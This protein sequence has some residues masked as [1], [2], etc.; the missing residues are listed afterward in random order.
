MPA[1]TAQLQVRVSPRE[2]AALRRRA[3]A[4]G[5]DVSSYVLARALPREA[6]TVAALL[7][8]LATASKRAFALAALGDL[9]RECSAGSFSDAVAHADV[10]ALAPYVQNYVAAMT[11]HA[12]HVHNVAPPEWVR[13][14]APLDEPHFGT[15]LVSLRP[16]LLRASPVAFKRRN[17]FIDATM[18]DRV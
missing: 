4:A 17:I 3:A 14:V 10:G 16:Y 11:E 8:A 9:L 13:D 7:R 1:K 2:K 12:A 5:L 15:L 6:D 18:H